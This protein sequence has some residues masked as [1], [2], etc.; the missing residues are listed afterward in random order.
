MCYGRLEQVDIRFDLQPT[1]S[2]SAPQAD[3]LFFEVLWVQNQNENFA[4]YR[5]SDFISIYDFFKK[6]I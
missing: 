3:C 2:Q 6:S 5:V 1:W 4:Y